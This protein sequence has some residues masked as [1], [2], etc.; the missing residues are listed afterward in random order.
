MSFDVFCPVICVSASKSTL[1]NRSGDYSYVQGSGDDH[2][3]WGRGLSPA[4]FWENKTKLLSSSRSELPSVVADITST[5][6]SQSATGSAKPLTYVST[7]HGKIIL[8]AIS[9]LSH[10]PLVEDTAYLLIGSDEDIRGM[11]LNE[12]TFFIKAVEGKKGQDHFVQNVLPLADQYMAKSLKKE[13]RV[14][15]ACAT[16]ND[17]AVGAALVALQ[18]YFNDN[19]ELVEATGSGTP[20]LLME[21]SSLHC[22]KQGGS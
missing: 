4:V 12:K 16:G 17:Q 6:A 5:A 18:K 10:R 11:H 9:D 20:Y 22:S 2:E 7:V 15:V 21:L 3:L 8:C 1:E 14:C 13:M 19:G